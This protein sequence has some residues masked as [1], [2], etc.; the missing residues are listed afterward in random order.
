MTC[1]RC[2]RRQPWPGLC[3]D[4]QAA[5]R[6]R[7]RRDDVAEDVEWMIETGETHPDAIATRLGYTTRAGLYISLRRAGRRDLIRQLSRNDD[8]EDPWVSGL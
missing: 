3:P 4:C 2:G 8:Q 7:R 1:S 6:P 5:R